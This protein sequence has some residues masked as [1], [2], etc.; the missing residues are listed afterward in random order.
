M[1]NIALI[2]IDV[3]TMLVKEK[4]Y[5][6]DLM[7]ETINQGIKQFRAHHEPV[8]FIQHT[9]EELVENTKDWEVSDQL[10]KDKSDICVKKSFN[11]FFKATQLKE[12]LNAKDVDTLVLCGMQT[13]YC[14]DASIKS[15]FEQ[16]YTLYVLKNAFSTFDTPL[17]SANVMNQHYQTIWSNEFATMIDVKEL[18]QLLGDK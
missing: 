11:S 6:V 4:P 16:D 7:L 9:N 13:E 8:I 18:G 14:L 15:A 1:N 17:L 12:I 2:I 5:N 3:Q 10:D